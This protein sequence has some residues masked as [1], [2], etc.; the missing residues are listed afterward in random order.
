MSTRDRLGT[1][2]PAPGHAPRSGVL[3]ALSSILGVLII[4]GTAWLLWPVSL[5]GRAQFII[6]QG[7]SME[8]MYHSGDLLY[9]RKSVNYAPGDV[10]V[11][12]IPEGDPGSGALVVHRIVSEDAAGR[13]RFKGDN[14]ESLDD[15]QPSQS[16]IVAKPVANLGQLPTRLIILTPFFLSIVFGAAVAWFLWPSKAAKKPAPEPNTEPEPEKEQQTEQQP[17]SFRDRTSTEVAPGLASRVDL[18]LASVE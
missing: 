4:L 13:Y 2:S 1:T 16:Y 6:V 14:R 10:A 15:A 7:T 18:E 3:R 12:T 8:P 9:A 5:G 17:E 11:Y